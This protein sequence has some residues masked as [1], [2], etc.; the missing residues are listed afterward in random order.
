MNFLQVR[1]YKL[2]AEKNCH[3]EC[4]SPN[5]KESPVV[6]WTSE[7]ENDGYLPNDG[8]NKVPLLPS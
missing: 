6:S 8:G 2:E 7:S 3:V 5:H 4:K 1:K